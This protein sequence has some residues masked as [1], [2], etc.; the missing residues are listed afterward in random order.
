MRIEMTVYVQKHR[1][2]S[3]RSPRDLSQGF[4]K[5]LEECLLSLCRALSVPIPLWLSKNTKEFAS[6]HLTLFSPE[7]FDERVTFDRMVLRML[8]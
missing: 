3:D 2:A 5:Q 1:R 7:Q 4:S 8:E 6:F